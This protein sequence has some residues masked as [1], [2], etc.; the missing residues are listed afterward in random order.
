MKL[1]RLRRLTFAASTNS[2]PRWV[3][4]TVSNDEVCLRQGGPQSVESRKR[5][6]AQELSCELAITQFERSGIKWQ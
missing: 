6:E 2:F 3:T 4:A 5:V 1:R